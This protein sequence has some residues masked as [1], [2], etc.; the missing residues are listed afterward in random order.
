MGES[1]YSSTILDLGQIHGPAALLL[2]VGPAF[3]VGYQNGWAPEPVWTLWRREKSL[4]CQKWDP[5]RPAHSLVAIWGANLILV[6]VVWRSNRM[7]LI[8]FKKE[9]HQRNFYYKKPAY[10]P[11][12][13]DYTLIWNMFSMWVILVCSEI[14]SKTIPLCCIICE[15]V[16]TFGKYTNANEIGME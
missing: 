7:L 15:E 11:Y 1:R 12:V 13:Y 14:R 5:C 6:P 8:Y 2:R 4:L 16:Y 9:A 3:P 10:V